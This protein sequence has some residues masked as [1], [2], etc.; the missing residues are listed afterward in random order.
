MPG[1]NTKTAGVGPSFLPRR[2][3]VTPVTSLTVPHPA[4]LHAPLC[5]S[6]AKLPKRLA[7]V[8]NPSFRRAGSV[9]RADPPANVLESSLRLE[10][11]HVALRLIIERKGMRA[12]PAFGSRVIP[13][14]VR[15]VLGLKPIKRLCA[16]RASLLTRHARQR[17]QR[18][19]A[20]ALGQ[21]LA[22]PSC[23]AR[24]LG[25]AVEGSLDYRR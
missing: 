15:A 17:L 20:R 14:C 3:P 19:A 21:K 24:A 5:V 12:G 2:R 1:E 25:L 8:G 16:G 18:C 13:K 6:L 11:A 23:A 22:R 4:R 7:N 9:Q 10:S